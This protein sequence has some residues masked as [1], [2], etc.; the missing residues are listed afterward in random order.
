MATYEAI[1]D[2]TAASALD[3]TETFEAVQSS[4]SVKAT[5]DQIATYVANNGTAQTVIVG[6]VISKYDTGWV[7]NSDWTNAELTVTH[8]L[9]HN[10]AELI[11]K[12]FLSTDDTDANS[13]ETLADTLDLGT[14]TVWENGITVYQTDTNTLKIQTADD[15]A[16]TQI[17]DDGS[18]NV[19]DADSYYYRVVVYYIGV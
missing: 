11:V 19:I 13:F 6:A 15:G 3:G 12:F 1:S 14:A 9:G 4:A 7:S 17:N 8:N 16:Y 10:L 2:L 5:T 18:R